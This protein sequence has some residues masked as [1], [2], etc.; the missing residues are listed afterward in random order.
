MI[1]TLNILFELAVNLA[2]GIIFVTFCYKFLEPRFSKALNI[3]FYILAVALMFGSISLMNY[4]ADAVENVE[5]LIFM[6]IMLPYSL[7][8]L[9]GRVYLK[10]LI[11]LIIFL[12]YICVASALNLFIIAYLNVDFDYLMQTSSEY[13][14]LNVLII[15]LS[16]IFIL[17]IIYR[18]WRRKF[19][20]KGYAD[21]IPF[22]ILPTAALAVIV[23]VTAISSDE[24]T[25]N[26]SRIYLGIIVAA[27]LLVAMIILQLMS[28]IS[29][30][31]EIKTQNLLMLKK[32]EMYK[33]Q[34]ND[35]NKYI[36]EIATVKHNM[37]NK[38]LC[39]GQL[40]DD[41]SEAEARKMCSSIMNELDDITGMF[42][43][44]NPCLNAILNVV[45]KKSKEQGI[46]IKASVK[47]DFIG[48]D[49]S[50]L[51]TLLG[52]LCDNAVEAEMKLPLHDRAI[53]LSLFEKGGCY[54]ITVKNR[55]EKSVL[56][57]NPK[58]E[59]GK[60]DSL[61]HGYGVKSVNGIVEKYSGAVEFS[62]E[63]GMFIA[64]VLLE[65]PSITK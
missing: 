2:Q 27:T 29:K 32:E 45:S 4:Y 54:F 23:L 15:N 26:L 56:E 36:E 43:T 50:D 7:F 53:R 58:L 61:Y 64:N 13:R 22:L 57:S 31:N 59:S 38:I 35:A 52:N 46:D 33:N 62:E 47:S 8:C 5:I 49:D 21:I 14:V 11:P 60:S 25:S 34:I 44:K 42:N 10:I 55:I 51:I 39:I 20:L 12:V 30:S 37:K 3:T 19:V 48:I 6:A 16:Y 1:D 41:G 65:I 18:V 17:F 63:S 28:E 9:K 24:S 40:I